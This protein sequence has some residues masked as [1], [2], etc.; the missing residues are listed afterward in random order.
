MSTGVSQPLG[1]LVRMNLWP[2]GEGAFRAPR[3][4][5]EEGAPC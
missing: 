4:Q 2:T 5:R 3:T 1:T